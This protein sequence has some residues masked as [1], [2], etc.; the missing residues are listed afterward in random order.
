MSDLTIFS[1]GSFRH[2]MDELIPLFQRQSLMDIN[3]VLAPAGLLRQRIERGE[4]CDIFISA[5]LQNIIQL[6]A[7]QCI[8]NQQILAFNRLILT[9][10]D[11]PQYQDRDTLDILFDPDLRLA[12][13]TPVADP[14]GDYTWQLFDLLEKR[15]PQQGE[16]LKRRALQL[17]GGEN[18]VVP[19]G[20]IASAYLLKQNYAD[21]MVGYAN[22]RS[23]LQHQGL[24]FHSLPPEFNIKAIYAAAQLNE[25]PITQQFF[26]FLTSAEAARIMYK[27]GFLPE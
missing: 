4:H 14:G 22:Y 12:T 10:R 16:R 24:R 15:Y 6:S 20:E 11:E 5:N 18:S 3:A 1:A 7:S 26:Q 27:Q 2:V 25:H 21:M 8:Y 17:V 9:T 13:S 19:K 23:H